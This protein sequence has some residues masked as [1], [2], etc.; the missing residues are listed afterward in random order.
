[1]CIHNLK[2]ITIT[3]QKSRPFLTIPKSKFNYS[4]LSLATHVTKKR[5]LLRNVKIWTVPFDTLSKG[6]GTAVIDVSK[7]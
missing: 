5:V 7:V 3:T 1:M 2:T 6:K 4:F